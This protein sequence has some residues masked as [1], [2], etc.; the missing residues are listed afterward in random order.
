MPV[1]KLVMIILYISSKKYV[2]I[3]AVETRIH[4][5]M[6][7]G[8]IKLKLPEARTKGHKPVQRLGVG[9]NA[10]SPEIVRIWR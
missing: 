9:L 7:R 3:P 1:G 2:W 4:F 5:Y 10:I 6:A 8:R